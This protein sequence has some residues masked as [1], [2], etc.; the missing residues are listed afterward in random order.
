MP[1]LVIYGTSGVVYINEARY[2]AV[3]ISNL[4]PSLGVVQ[5]SVIHKRITLWVKC[6]QLATFSWSKLLDENKTLLSKV[7]HEF[8]V[9]LLFVSVLIPVPQ[10]EVARILELA[11]RACTFCCMYV[12]VCYS[13]TVKHIC[14]LAFLFVWEHILQ[15]IAPIYSNYLTQGKTGSVLLE[16]DQN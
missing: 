7:M 16:N 4:R 14:M 8:S 5:Q 15:N 9:R 11:L 1:V 12:V 6:L 10:E 13:Q 3:Y 2:L